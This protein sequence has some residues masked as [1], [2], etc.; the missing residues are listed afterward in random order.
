MCTI[1][2]RLATLLAAIP[3]VLAA[4][5]APWYQ[6]DF[7]P[8]EFRARWERV[9]SK[10]GDEAVAVL[11]GVPQ[12]SGFIVPRQTNEFYYLC[13]VE[14]PHSYLLLDGRRRKVLLYLPPRNPRLESAEGKVLSAEDAGLVKSLTGADEVVSNEAMRPDWLG[15]LPGGAPRVI[16]TPFSPGEGNGQ[17]RYELL[18]A[19]AAI[20][21]DYWD[22]RLP[23]EAQFAEL[24][25]A[26]YPRAKIL[27]LTP[28]LDEMRSIK[29]PREI[30][31]IRRAS[32]LAGLGLMEAMRSTRPSLYEYQL[33]AAA[34]YVFL[35]NGARLE[36]YRSITAAGTEVPVPLRRIVR[37]QE[38]RCRRRGSLRRTRRRG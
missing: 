38:R 25:R 17:S 22:G 27:D 33:D 30:S 37:P 2:V 5:P 3:A 23:R 31:L 28:I 24:L 13:G 26:R 32:Q 36:G 6:T 10:I 1:R 18:A 34:R 16:Y 19:N 7:S 15:A 29:S 14:T 35:V 12:T 9:F 4:Q 20:A 21:S 8:E 11:Q